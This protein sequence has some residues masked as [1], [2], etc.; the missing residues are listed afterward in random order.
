MV[1]RVKERRGKPRIETELDARITADDVGMEAA[2]K[3][4]SE[5]GLLLITDRPVKELS[6]VGLK[7][8]LPP[9]SPHAPRVAFELHGAVVR[10]T[11]AGKAHPKKWE[12]AVFMTGMPAEAKRALHDYVHARLR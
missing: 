5:S 11:K 12:I 10:C 3:N 9:D 1:E 6:L 2:V 4:L 8:A 7:L